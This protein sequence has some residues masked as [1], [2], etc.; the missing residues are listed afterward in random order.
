MIKLV[1]PID[2]IDLIKPVGL[3]DPIGLKNSFSVSKSKF[4]MRLGLIKVCIL[5]DVEGNYL[6][7]VYV[8]SILPPFR[9]HLVLSL[10]MPCTFVHPFVFSIT[11][12]KCSL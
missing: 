1:T 9:F 11:L 8:H 4:F 3:V 2:S 10:I 12:I 6:V 5:F 7:L